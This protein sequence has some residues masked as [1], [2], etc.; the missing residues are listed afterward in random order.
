MKHLYIKT[1]GC[2]M[3]S[4]DSTRMADLLGESHAFQSTDDPEKADL[5]ILNTCHI[6]EKAED[7]LFSELGR[8]RPLA[9]RGVILA[10]GGCVG[11]AEGRTIFSRAPYVRMVFGP[12]NYHKLP[13]MI[14]RAL[15]GETRV[16]AED[17]PSVDKF[18]NLPQVRAQGVVGQ[19]T[20]QEGCDKFCAF[21]VVPYTRG[22]EWSRPVAAILAETEALAQQGVR[23]VLLLGQN[24]NAYAGVDE[25][26]VSYDLALLIRRVALIEGIE[27]IRF[28]TSHPVDMNE[29][30]VEVFGEIEQLAPYLHLPIQSGSDAILAAMQRGHTVEEYC[31]WVEKVRAVCPDVALASDFIVG[32]PGETEQDFQAT[33]DLISRLGFDHAYSFKYSSRPGT[34]AADMPEQVDEAEKSRRLERLQQ[35]LNTQQLQRNKARVGRRESVLVEGVSK[36]RDGELSGRSGTLR[37]VNFAGPVAL[38]GQFV[39]VEIVEGL[40]NSLRGRLV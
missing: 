19:V 21:C 15:D 27:R 23:E 6:R 34:P 39:D 18:D 24:V 17:I 8:L 10:V 35:L 11:Q 22:R 37:T 31:T 4:Y 32:F 16:I 38:I 5:I 36:K 26:G 28:V 2:Q 13:Q 9:E 14:Q 12:Q 30:L 25:E 40:P 3:N 29:D 33:L 1:F 7:K 20:V